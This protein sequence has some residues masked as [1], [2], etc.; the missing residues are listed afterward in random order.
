MAKV[1]GRRYDLTKGNHRSQILSEV[2]TVECSLEV[3]QARYGS[4]ERYSARLARR[5]VRSAERGDREVWVLVYGAMEPYAALFAGEDLRL[6][7]RRFRSRR[8]AEAWAHRLLGIPP[9][10]WEEDGP[11]QDVVH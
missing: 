5:L 11:D 1:V 3:Y 10:N 4:D 9:E 2:S 8:A 6:R 7:R